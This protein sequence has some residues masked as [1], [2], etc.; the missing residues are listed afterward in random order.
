[1]LLT[2]E[3]K[4]KLINDDIGTLQEVKAAFANEPKDIPWISL[5]KLDD[6][7][8]ELILSKIFLSSSNDIT[9]SDIREKLARQL[10]GPSLINFLE[11]NKSTISGHKAFQYYK[12]RL[13]PGHAYDL[14]FEDIRQNIISELIG[15]FSDI[16]EL[17]VPI[18]AKETIRI[19]E[20]IR[21]KVLKFVGKKQI[22]RETII[23]E[24]INELLKMETKHNCMSFKSEINICQQLLIGGSNIESYGN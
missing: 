8:A 15:N 7:T 3:V 23:K 17:S 21:E 24:M 2:W 16:T 9:S 11:A 1:M 12:E 22:K 13:F 4:T 19:L 18:G 6:N 14:A 5:Q 10:K 20:T